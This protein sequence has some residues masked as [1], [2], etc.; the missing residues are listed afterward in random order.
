MLK[1]L[2]ISFILLIM[3]VPLLFLKFIYFRENYIYNIFLGNYIFFSNYLLLITFV[4]FIINLSFIKIDKTKYIILTFIFL[5]IF[6][7]VGNNNF[8]NS[9]IIETNISINKKSKMDKLKIIFISD[10]HLSSISNKEMFRKSFD[11]INRLNGDII[12][13]G[14]D[15]L[16]YS[17]KEVK[18][19]Y[20]DIFNN[21]KSKYGVY[22][23]LGNHEYYGGVKGNENYIKSLGIK[24]LKDTIFS[25]EDIYIIGRDDYHNKL[26][27]DLDSL[28][29]N[30]P[31][32]S[33][34]I[35]IDHNPKSIEETIKVKGDLQLSGHTHKGQFFPYNLIVDY[36]Y[37]N[38]YG[39]KKFDN[40]HTIV[41]AGL[42]SWQVPYRIGSTSEINIIN[43]NF[44]K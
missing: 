24:V 8:K 41:T 34:K 9:K 37:K 5:I 17:Y 3:T 15:I 25:I 33:P 22:G 10:L 1:G 2:L 18:E 12:I 35:V 30:L 28:F 27:R 4:L 23:V 11:K 19:D 6:G 43:I 13:L 44:K 31:E 40:L 14:G 42:G 38:G 21:L 26:R 39:Y 20:S 7:I 16:D 29:K 36:M 32:K